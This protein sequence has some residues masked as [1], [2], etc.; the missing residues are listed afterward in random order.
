MYGIDWV[1]DGTPIDWSS[2]DEETVEMAKWLVQALEE[3]RPGLYKINEERM[4]V[5][6]ASCR[7]CK[8]VFPKA[9]VTFVKHEPMPEAGYIKVK[10]NNLICDSTKLFALAAKA[11]TNVEIY[12]M[13]DGSIEMFLTYYGITNYVGG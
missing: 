1:D 9:E 6:E 12:P 10:S 3:T 2:L 4:R 8:T 5:F 13:L 7:I 11:A